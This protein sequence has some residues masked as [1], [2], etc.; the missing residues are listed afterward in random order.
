M[1]LLALILLVAQAGPPLRPGQPEPDPAI[2]EITA[3]ACTFESALRGEHCLYEGAPVQVDP[4]DNAGLALDAGKAECAR[5][6]AGDDDLRKEC[7]AG[8]GEAARSSSCARAALADAAGH[9]APGARDC[10]AALG[11][12]LRRTFTSAAWAL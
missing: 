1:R 7:E 10:V 3:L 6:S 5:Q 9:L 2:G 11:A 4:R 12:V 8:V